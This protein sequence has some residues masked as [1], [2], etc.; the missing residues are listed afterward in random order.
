MNGEHNYV[1]LKPYLLVA[2][3]SLVVVLITAIVAGRLLMPIIGSQTLLQINV[4]TTMAFN[5]DPA[6][7]KAVPVPFIRNSNLVIHG[8]SLNRKTAE[9]IVKIKPEA[10]SYLTEQWNNTLSFEH[11]AIM[12][13]TTTQECS[14]PIKTT[15]SAAG[16]S[17]NT[18]I[19]IHARRFTLSLP[20]S[21]VP[22]QIGLK[23]ELFPGTSASNA[24]KIL[25]NDIAVRCGGSQP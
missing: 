2:V 3:G 7:N 1:S 9:F 17:L 4:A 16:N 14:F 21:H 19:P 12:H 20:L 18:V 15:I 8:D 6:N 5:V 24:C 23:F 22:P 11:F 25:L 13:V 10:L